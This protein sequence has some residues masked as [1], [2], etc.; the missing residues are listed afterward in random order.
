MNDTVSRK[1]ALE[2]LSTLHVSPLVEKTARK[3]LN[4]LPSQ[5]LQN[6]KEDAEFLNTHTKSIREKLE[7]MRFQRDK[8]AKEVLE[9]KSQVTQNFPELI[10]STIDKISNDAIK[11][12]Q[13]LI[14][15][16]EPPEQSYIKSSLSSV[17]EEVLRSGLLGVGRKDR[18]W[19]SLLSNRLEVAPNL[20]E[21]ITHFKDVFELIENKA[22]LFPFFIKNDMRVSVS[23]AQTAIAQCEAVAR[24]C[25]PTVI[26]TVNTGGGILGNYISER[27]RISNQRVISAKTYNNNPEVRINTN[28]IKINKN[29]RILIVDDIARTGRTMRSVYDDLRT[30]HPQTM[31]RCLTLVAHYDNSGESLKGINKYSSCF[32]SSEKV[33]LPWSNSGQLVHRDGV[34]IIGKGQKTIAITDNEADLS[35]Q[36]VNKK[37]STAQN[38]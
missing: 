31:I 24:L 16:Q 5:K 27:L 13:T 25:S 19:Q 7:L 28:S 30:K 10:S 29:S 18:S 11:T 23:E 6:M 4:N 22:R 14:G 33:E 17:L 36:E 1:E 38:C 8:Q 21:G 15:F 12:L 34:F 35:F 3:A 26:V 20:P 37:T 32:T 2:F 9:Y